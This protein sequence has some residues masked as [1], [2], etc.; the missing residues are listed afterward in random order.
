MNN[1]TK[2][3]Y[4]VDEYEFFN[5]DNDRNRKNVGLHVPEND[6]YKVFNEAELEQITGMTDN[7]LPTINAIAYGIPLWPPGSS[8]E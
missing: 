2:L 5:E 3:I 6:E 4:A 1:D 7:D 8:D